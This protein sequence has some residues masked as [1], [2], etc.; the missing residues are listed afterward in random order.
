MYNSYPRF[1]FEYYIRINLNN[2]GTARNYIGTFY[3]APM[4]DQVSPLVKT[5]EL[6]SIKI[7]TDEKS[8]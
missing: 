4:W 3:N 1:P 5:V 8:I 2:V 7:D 6:P